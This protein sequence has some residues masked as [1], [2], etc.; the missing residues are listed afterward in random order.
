MQQK[1]KLKTIAVYCFVCFLVCLVCCCCCVVVAF[2]VFVCLVCVFFCCFC[3]VLI[4][5]VPYIN[6]NVLN[7]FL[8]NNWLCSPF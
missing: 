1:P 2:V 8:I 6:E 4:E 3:G 7:K 5:I